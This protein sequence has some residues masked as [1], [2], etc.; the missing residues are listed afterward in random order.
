MSTPGYVLFRLGA[1]TFATVLDDVREIVRLDGLEELPN[2]TPPL[3]GVLVLR[4]VPL[5]VLDVR[6]TAAGAG[7]DVL[8][9][10]VADEP[11]G[12]AVDQVVAV[13]SSDELPDGGVPPRSLPPYVVGVRQG[14][15]GPVLLVDIHALLDTAAAGW[16]DSVVAPTPVTA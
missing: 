5:P 6:P 12:V 9:L 11:V 10:Q 4:G 3:R 16:T 1:R 7:G 8:V 13:V 14:P 15:G 2:M